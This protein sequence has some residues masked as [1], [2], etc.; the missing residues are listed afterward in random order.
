[1]L[2]DLTLRK[3]WRNLTPEALLEIESDRIQSKVEKDVIEVLNLDGIE[4]KD[5]EAVVFR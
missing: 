4:G 1:V 5:I 3:N 2:Y